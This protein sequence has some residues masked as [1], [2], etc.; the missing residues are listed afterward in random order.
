[1][2]LPPSALAGWLADPGRPFR[3]RVLVPY[4][5]RSLVLIGANGYGKTRL[6]SAILDPCTPRLFTRL[7]PRVAPYLAAARARVEAASAGSAGAGTPVDARRVAGPADVVKLFESGE[8]ARAASDDHAWWADLL[9]LPGLHWVVAWAGDAAP[10][11]LSAVDGADPLAAPAAVIH[12]A[13][14]H[15]AGAL[16]RWTNP[17]ELSPSSMA[18]AT[19]DAFR[20]WAA[21]VLSAC[22]GRYRVSAN[23]LIAVDH[24]DE[25]VSLLSLGLGF[26]RELAARAAARLELLTG[27]AVELRC[28]PAERFAWQLRADEGWIPLDWASRAVSRWAA[29]TARETLKEFAQHAAWAAEDAGADLAAVLR[30][31]LDGTLLPQGKPQ[32]FASQSSWVALDEPEVHLFAS[33]ARHLGGV[34]AEHGRAGRTVIVT[35]SLDLAA[36]FVGN[37]DFV[38]F[39]APGRFTVDRPGEDLSRLLERLAESGPGILA[40]TRVLYVEGKWDMVLVKLMHEDLLARHNILLSP[41]HG[42]KGANLAASSVWQRMMTTPFG[43]MFDAISAAAAERTWGTVREQVAAGRRGQAL[44]QLREQIRRA[45]RGPFEE[46]ELLRMFNAVVEGGLEARLHLVMHGLSDVFQV[47]H[48]SVFGLPEPTWRAAG[49]EGRGSFK[50]FIRAQAGVDL[51]DGAQCVQLIDAFTAAGTPTDPEASGKLSA[52]L[53]AFAATPGPEVSHPKGR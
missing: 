7:P 33:E 3:G 35:H 22:G 26:A 53:L 30:G 4:A 21:D 9:G 52:A 2:N 6:L 43:M 17:D 5:Q 15:V 36:Q 47:M 16:E 14:R 42:V 50:D 20:G 11:T 38:T 49:Y 44:Y 48:P 13:P 32:P 51:K 31:S 19:E 29:L 23:P 46:V 10:A 40:G 12:A 28:L 1:M 24:G 37:A 25:S 45:Q 41:M 39:D 18:Q 8:A 34:L 27:L